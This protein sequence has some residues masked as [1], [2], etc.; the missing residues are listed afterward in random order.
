MSGRRRAYCV[1]SRSA[2]KEG[3][4]SLGTK[5]A[6]LVVGVGNMI[7]RDGGLLDG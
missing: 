4:A 3:F 5:V 7:F 6:R 2:G 1:C